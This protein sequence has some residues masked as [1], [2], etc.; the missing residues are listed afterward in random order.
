[1][2]KDSHAIKEKPFITK[3]VSRKPRLSDFENKSIE[4]NLDNP[5]LNN[6]I[7]GLLSTMSQIDW[8]MTHTF[9]EGANVPTAINLMFAIAT[10]IFVPE[11]ETQLLK[12]R[13]RL[14][15]QQKFSVMKVAEAKEI[16]A[17]LNIYLGQTYFAYHN[18]VKP[19]SKTEPH[20]GE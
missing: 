11:T 16:Y 15:Y 18:S 4:F 7:N 13:E 20:I 5:P 12:D 2:R 17:R 6:F 9:K 10:K 1:M 8:H 3:N 14:I 19:R